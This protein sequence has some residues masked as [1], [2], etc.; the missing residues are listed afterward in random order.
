[1]MRRHGHTN[2]KMNECNLRRVSFCHYGNILYNSN[3]FP[4][5]SMNDIIY[6][7]VRDFWGV[8]IMILYNH[9]SHNEFA[10]YFEAYQARDCKTFFLIIERLRVDSICSVFVDKE[11]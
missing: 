9:N 10:W 6:H 4:I 7:I 3:Y 1:M 2:G 5:K 8:K 11:V